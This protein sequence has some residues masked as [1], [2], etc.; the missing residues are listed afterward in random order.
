MPTFTNPK[1]LVTHL[2]KLTLKPSNQHTYTPSSASVTNTA[3][4]ESV[5]EIVLAAWEEHEWNGSAAALADWLNARW[6]KTGYQVSEE[7]LCFTLRLYGRDARIGVGDCLDGAFVRF[8]CG[9]GG[10]GGSGG[11]LLSDA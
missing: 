11:S 1:A 6:A 10:S 9:V 5:V 4:P 3:L 8:H 7:T 2:A